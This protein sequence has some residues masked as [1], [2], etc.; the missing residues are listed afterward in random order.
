MANS[1]EERQSL[2]IHYSPS[3][4][5]SLGYLAEYLDDIDE[6]VHFAQYNR[7]EKRWNKLHSQANVYTKTGVGLHD[8]NGGQAAYFTG[9]ATDWETQRYFVSYENRYLDGEVL[10]GFFRQTAR[11]GVAPYIGE[12]GDLHTWLMLE[13]MHTPEAQDNLVITPLVR[14]FKSTVLIELG[15]NENGHALANTILRF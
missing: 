14:L 10:N 5:Y 13:A 6:P 8:E 11:V 7:L 3:F 4:Q 1:N 12:Y 15:V 9:F 2:H